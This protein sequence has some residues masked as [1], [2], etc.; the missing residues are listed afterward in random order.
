M[1]RILVEYDAQEEC[2]SEAVER[3]MRTKMGM[4]NPLPVFVLTDIAFVEIKVKPSVKNM[5]DDYLT[6]VSCN[7]EIWE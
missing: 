2:L 4:E 7:L 6:S 5:S 1:A 3:Y